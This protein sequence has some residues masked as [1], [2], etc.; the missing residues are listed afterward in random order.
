[1]DRNTQLIKQGRRIKRNTLIDGVLGQLQIKLYYN[2][3]LSNGR[4]KTGFVYGSA[5]SY[6]INSDF[7]NVRKR[8]IMSALYSYEKEKGTQIIGT[9]QFLELNRNIRYQIVEWNIYYREYQYYKI[10]RV[11][12]RGK[13]YN[14]VF[15]TTGKIQTVQKWKPITQN[16]I[17]TD[18][19]EDFEEL[20][21]DQ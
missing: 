16:K 7:N 17:M 15:D 14:Y 1:M 20:G 3:Y 5:S 12:R 2:E 8:A 6:R 21:I 4:L 13:Y 18:V 10:K 11:K 19:S 9:N